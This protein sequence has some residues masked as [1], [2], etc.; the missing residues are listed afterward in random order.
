MRIKREIDSAGC[1]CG[2]TLWLSARNTYDWAT[3]PGA[4]WPCSELSNLPLRISVDR[5]GL[6]DLS[7]DRGRIQD[8]SG[9]ELQAIVSDHL[10]IDCQ[11]FWPI[12]TQEGV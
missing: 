6:W 10:P 5:N 4:A 7:I 8:C 9:H 11:H 12:W 1:V 3:R 2:Y